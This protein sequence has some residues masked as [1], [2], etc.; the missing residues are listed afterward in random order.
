MKAPNLIVIV[1]AAAALAGCVSVKVE[2]RVAPDAIGPYSG[3]VLADGFCF[4]SGKIGTR[5]GSF[6]EEA[7]SALDAVEAELHAAGLDLGDLVQVTVYLTDMDMY[8]A[9]N[10][11][12]A[13][14]VPAPYPARVCVAVA[15]L[16][17][18]ARVEIQ[19]TARR[20]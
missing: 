11:I 12:Y 5:G 13:A 3:A 16:P 10:E 18:G 6:E 9:F 20:R 7:S 14:R 4:V 17:G 2:H 8:G 1:V 19:G 15:A